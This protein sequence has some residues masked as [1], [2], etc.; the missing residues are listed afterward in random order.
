M[1]Y[2]RTCFFN[3]ARVVT[4]FFQDQWFD[5]T[6]RVRTSGDVSLLSAG[7]PG[8][9]SEFYQPAR[10]AHI[11]EALRALPISD[12]SRYIYVDLGSGKGRTLFIAAERPFQK[13]L[14]VELSPVLHQQAC[15]NIRTF[16]RRHPQQ[17]SSIFQNALDFRFPDD[18]LVLYMFNPFGRE[19]MHRVLTN[20]SSS[21]GSNP[22][23]VLIILLWP[24]CGDMV[25]SLVDMKI[26]HEN[27]HTQIFSNAH[28]ISA[29]KD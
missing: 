6:R 5:R 11:R 10:P 14:G 12:P 1:N 25:A 16:R 4:E 9:D 24:R 23:H 29:P 22:R 21:V 13:I 27:R 28:R 7:I 18:R 20:L 19:T 26:V 2:L 15:D 3:L 17:I 8:G